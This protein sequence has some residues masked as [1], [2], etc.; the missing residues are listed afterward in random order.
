MKIYN[1]GKR[2]QVLK[3][4]K[5]TK[6]LF[7]N[8]GSLRELP[9]PLKNFVSIS[10][11]ISFSIRIKNSQIRVFLALLIHRLIPL[12]NLFVLR[13]ILVGGLLALIFA[14]TRGG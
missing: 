12:V 13:S 14:G 9:H 5:Q 1:T 2:L 4:T 7:A 6:L 8:Q 3:R 10:E 11:L